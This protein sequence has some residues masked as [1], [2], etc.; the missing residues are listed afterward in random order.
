MQISILFLKIK[1]QKIN[2][3]ISSLM[4][5]QMLRRFLMRNPKLLVKHQ[6]ELKMDEKRLQQLDGLIEARVNYTTH[7]LHL[8][9]S[10]QTPLSQFLLAV[11]AL[12]YGIKPYAA[13]SEQAQ[14]EQ[15]LKSYL[16]R[17]GIASLGMMQVMMNAVFLYIS[18]DLEWQYEQIIRWA[19]LIIATPVV[20]YSAYPFFKSAW[21][22]MKTRQLS[23][24]F[25]VALAIAAAYID[26]FYPHGSGRAAIAGP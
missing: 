8:K 24:D 10:P 11:R 3:P 13:T 19:S 23:M 6:Q 20:F 4:H 12:G 15:E 22:D 2:L 1:N 17:I 14:K 26:I 9:W 16:A 5:R 18:G 25:P 7:R 21:R